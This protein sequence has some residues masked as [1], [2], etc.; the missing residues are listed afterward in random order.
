M[1]FLLDDT[2]DI[3]LSFVE[4]RN[5]GTKKFGCFLDV[6][7]C[8]AAANPCQILYPL[9]DTWADVQKNYPTFVDLMEEIQRLHEV[10]RELNQIRILGIDGDEGLYDQ[11]LEEWNNNLQENQ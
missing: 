5:R 9:G 7:V 4:Q 2:I 1:R 10:C 3:E 6:T 8:P 11:S